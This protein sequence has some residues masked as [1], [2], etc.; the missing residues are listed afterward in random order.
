LLVHA[1]DILGDPVR[2]RLLELLASSEHSSG[3]LAEVIADEFGISHPAVSQHL[4]VL[5]DNGFATVRA[6]GT[7][8]IYAVDP[9]PIRELDAWVDQFRG[10]WSQRLDALGTELRR[11][12]RDRRHRDEE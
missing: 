11:G 7:R 8:R 1:F 4:K 5:R 3:E 12:R 9:E 6:E 10:F 2:R